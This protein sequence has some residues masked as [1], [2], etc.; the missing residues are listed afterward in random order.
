MTAARPLHSS[1][2]AKV[3]RA[4]LETDDTCIENLLLHRLRAY[5]P[6]KPRPFQAHALFQ[7]SAE[8]MSDGRN[9]TSYKSR[10]T[11]TETNQRFRLFVST[12]FLN[13]NHFGWNI[14]LPLS[15]RLDDNT[16]PKVL[17]SRSHGKGFSHQ[18]VCMAGHLHYDTLARFDG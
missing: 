13:G 16:F 4:F 5:F 9:I 11:E 14:T 1:A 17:P 7:A 15:D 18:G 3:A 10:K 12:P 6:H 2:D 8:G